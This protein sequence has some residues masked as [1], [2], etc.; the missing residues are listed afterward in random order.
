MGPPPGWQNPI[1]VAPGKMQYGVDPLLLL[2]S[3]PDL[4]QGSLDLQRSLL[5]AG[6]PRRTPIQVT[7]DG[8][9]WDGHHAVRLAAEDGRK[10][11]VKVVPLKELP[12][13][14][15]ILALPVR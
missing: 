13:A 6:L 5:L 15:S 9:I 4:T 11:D 12:S 1:S 3:R 2:P 8:V 14:P 10:V 7:R